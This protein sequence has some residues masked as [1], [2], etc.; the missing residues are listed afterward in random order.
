MKQTEKG[1]MLQKIESLIP[2]YL[3]EWR[4]D[5]AAPDSGTVLA[6]LVGEMLDES[7]S[8]LEKVLNKHK[9]SYLNLFDDLKQ[10]PIEVSTGFVQ[11]TP[12]VGAPSPVHVPQHTRLL[13]QSDAVEQDILFETTHGITAAQTELACVYS[14]QG[15]KDVICNLYSAE[16]AAQ[17]GKPLRFTAFDVAGKNET[18]H[19]LTL[20]FED[21]LEGMH[22]FRFGLRLQ[23]VDPADAP[24]AV[25]RMLEGQVRFSLRDPE[26]GDIVIE[27]VQADGNVIWLTKEGYLPQ[28]VPFA[29]KELFVIDLSAPQVLPIAVTS[30]ELCVEQENIRPDGIWCGRVEQTI[31]EVKPFGAPLE[32]FSE[33]GIESRDVLSKKGARVQMSF[34][35]EFDILERALPVYE[36]A[37]TFKIIMKK[38][39]AV[40]KLAPS[41][42]YADYVLVEYL[43][44]RGWKRLLKEEHLALL[45]NTSVQGE[46]KLDF[47]CPLDIVAP[48]QAPE[49]YR[50]RLRLLKS[51]HLY[52]IPCKQYCPVMKDITFSYET[53]S[54]SITPYRAIAQQSFETTDVTMRLEHHRLVTLFEGETE[55]RPC[56]Y[57]GFTNPPVGT[58]FSLYLGIENHADIPVPLKIEYLGAWGFE[59]ATVIDNTQGLRYSGTLLLA[60]PSSCAKR[61]MFG[62]S[63]Y[64][65]R[66]LKQAEPALGV[67]VLANA[68]SLHAQRGVLPTITDIYLNIAKAENHSTREKYYYMNDPYAAFQIDLGEGNLVRAKVWVNEEGGTPER[69]HWVLWHKR[70]NI[71][72]TGRVYHIDYAVGTIVFDRGVFASIPVRKNAS[73]VKVQYQSYM[74]S[75]ANVAQGAIC[76][77]GDTLPYIASV[78]NPIA[79]FGGYDG[80]HEEASARITSSLLRT[81]NRAVTQAD[82]WDMIQQ[83]TCE[84]RRM[85]ALNGIDQNGLPKE[86]SITIALLINQ[87]DMG[88][89]VFSGI[90]DKVRA[91]IEAHSA[92]NPLGKNLILM[93]PRFLPFSVSLWMESE[94]MEHAYDQQQ[95]TEQVIG[96]F[97]NPLDGGFEG[98]GWQIGEIPTRQQLLAYLGVK[99][100]N[101]RVTHLAITVQYGAQE[102]AIDDFLQ[103]KR[104]DPFA[105][106]VSGTHVIY[107][108]VKAG[109]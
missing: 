13:A 22:D 35:L 57:F 96:R 8:R 26:L 3:P 9:V 1:Q 14:T 7:A 71:H 81:R 92:M 109:M 6:Q 84:V 29:E 40:P 21:V 50:L 69:E 79:A 68:Q 45:F 27:Q 56:M 37:T 36:E 5:S 73:S 19:R 75:S 88:G 39:Q 102:Y 90:K 55:R 44:D 10:E 107:V 77:L 100:P 98:E 11:F 63:L 99:C 78:S 48:D 97:L 74:G 85:K 66:M 93:Q 38:P 86:D 31:D 106:A 17:A 104:S 2:T 46:V 62:Q 30:I 72:E 20:A 15:E 33:C 76:R 12:V 18:C 70:E 28:R 65:V 24:K 89:Y 64:W 34:T 58:P 16:Q 91:Q 94:D 23:T 4:Y 67:S 83:A 42:V 47:D 60:I 52:Q 101:L 105:M 49:G 108:D 53:N 32:I 54:K 51:D 59:T 80:Y 41:D 25:A 87:Y 82:Y 103:I 61:T 43:S 95:E